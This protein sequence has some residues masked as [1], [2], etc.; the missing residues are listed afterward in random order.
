MRRVN[1]PRASIALW[2][3]GLAL[4]EISGREREARQAIEQFLDESIALS[5]DPSV[6]RF[7]SYAPDRLAEIDARIAGTPND[8]E[9]RAAADDSPRTEPRADSLSPAG[10]ILMS[11]GGAVL[12]AATIVGI[13]A[14]VKDS[15]LFERCGGT[16]CLNTADNHDAYDAMRQFAIAAD[17]LF[18]SGALLAV[19]GLV[20]TLATIPGDADEATARLQLRPGAGADMLQFE[21]EF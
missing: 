12:V 20:V 4:M 2:N 14:L 5:E 16:A 10:P 19:G 8:E 9:R 7:R 18:V 3:R 21:A 6:A 15:D 17:V 11:A 1:H 13:V